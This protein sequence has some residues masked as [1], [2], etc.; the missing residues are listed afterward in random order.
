MT[1]LLKYGFCFII[2]TTTILQSC[3]DDEISIEE[4]TNCST[5]AIYHVMGLCYNGEDAGALE[6]LPDGFFLIISNLFTLIDT[7]DIKHEDLIMV[8]FERFDSTY[9]YSPASCG[10]NLH[11]PVTKLTCISF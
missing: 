2:L 11:A 4:S 10:G 6:I 9:L 7:E 1:Q 5:Q 3:K 8:D